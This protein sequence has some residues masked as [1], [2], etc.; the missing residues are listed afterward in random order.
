MNNFNWR[1][2]LTIGVLMVAVVIIVNLAFSFIW[3]HSAPR[4]AYGY[5]PYGPGTMMGP[6]MWGGMGFFWIFP[7]IGFL[8]MLIIL[9]FIGS[10]LFGMPGRF[11]PPSAG[12][13]SPVQNVPHALEACKNCGRA[14]QTDWLAC[15]YC[16]AARSQTRQLEVQHPSDETD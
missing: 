1:T 9:G 6:W 16:G 8:F 4:G 3:A 11:Q 10:A 15:P 7:L 2:L 14:L 12:S 5:P 13:L